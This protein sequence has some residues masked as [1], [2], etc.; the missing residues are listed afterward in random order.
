MPQIGDEVVYFRQ[1]YDLYKDEV[2]KSGVYEL[3]EKPSKQT[4]V[5]E[6]CKVI[7]MKIEIKPPRLVCLKLGII[8]PKN[9]KLTGENFS[10]KYH[11]MPHVVDFVILRQFYERGLERNWRP[12]DRFKC[13][14]DDL[15]YI[16]T[17]TTKQPFQKEYP[18]CEFQSLSIVWDSGGEDAMSPWDLEPISG[19]NSRKSKPVSAAVVTEHQE[20]TLDELKSLLYVPHEDEWP[21]E[22]GRD[23]ECERI[24][25]VFL[26]FSI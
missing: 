16:G 19:V 22:H 24:L 7:G 5:Q 6:F 1:G 14:I 4:Q 12:K 13:L 3:D 9:S 15:W 2:R 17:I 8:D 20:V 25:K 18:E 11:D 10:I 23:E 26:L 21:R